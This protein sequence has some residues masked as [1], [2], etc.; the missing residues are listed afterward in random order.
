[1]NTFYHVL[2]I[3]SS[4]AW[5]Y[6]AYMSIS[7]DKFLKPMWIALMFIGIFKIMIKIS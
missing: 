1:M 6:F 4:S 7:K 2:L 3:I 5:G